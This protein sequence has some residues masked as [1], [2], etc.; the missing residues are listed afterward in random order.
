MGKSWR[1][2]RDWHDD[3]ERAEMKNRQGKRHKREVVEPDTNEPQQRRGRHSFDE[4][5]NF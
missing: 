4:D 2:S 5:D 3:N 1:D